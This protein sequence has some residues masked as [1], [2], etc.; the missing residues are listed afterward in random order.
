M[1]K[2][3][4]LQLHRQGTLGERVEKAVAVLNA[5]RLC[6]H[7]CGV[8]RLAGERGIC[9]TGRHAKVASY[10]AHFGEEAP[11]VGRFGSGTIFISSC[12]LF[13]LFCQNYEISHLSEGV[14]V[15]PEQM[16]AMMLRLARKGC[17]NINFVTPTHVVPQILEGLLIAAEEGLD[18]PLVYNSGGYDSVETLKLLEGIFDI[19]MPDFKFWDS[20]QAARF[21][22]AVDY[23]ERAVEAIREMHRQVGDLEL[24]S[25]GIALRGLLVRHLVMPHNLAGTPDVMRFLADEISINTYVNIMDQYRPCYRSAEDRLINRPVTGEEFNRAVASAEAAGLRRLDPLGRF[26]F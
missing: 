20:Q 22:R 1:E 14:E 19:Y 26:L 2:P 11:L 4:Y 21:C 15:A 12:N 9:R 24:D 6:P 13:C 17:H 5:C 23:R 3:S 8:N 18:V 16:A 10:H 7:E 25:N